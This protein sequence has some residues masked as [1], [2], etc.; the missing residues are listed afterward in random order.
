MSVDLDASQLV[1]HWAP[2]A[3][4]MSNAIE[5]SSFSK[6]C[7]GATKSTVDADLKAGMGASEGFFT[8]VALFTYRAFL[9]QIRDVPRFALELIYQVLP[10]LA[11]G[12]ATNSEFCT[13]VL[14]IINVTNLLF[15]YSSHS[16]QFGAIVPFYYPRIVRANIIVGCLLIFSLG[17][18]P[19][20]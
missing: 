14:H 18:N 17:A 6:E 7:N 3:R 11:L 13:S 16:G 15:R 4:A 20:L 1:G 12:F 9:Q 8:Q 10:G 19:K 2:R 5:S